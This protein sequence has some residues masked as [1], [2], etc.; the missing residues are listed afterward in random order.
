MSIRNNWRASEKVEKKKYTTFWCER[1]ESVYI[2]HFVSIFRKG[3]RRKKTV[4]IILWAGWN[5][6]VED[7]RWE[8]KKNNQQRMIRMSG[9]RCFCETANLIVYWPIMEKEEGTDYEYHYLFV[10]IL[11]CFFAL[12]YPTPPCQ[13]NQQQHHRTDLS[14]FMLHA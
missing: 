8:K 14:H 6:R 1:F 3:N 5:R 12:I 4:P 7:D 13:R 11:F 9:M 2:I 10:I